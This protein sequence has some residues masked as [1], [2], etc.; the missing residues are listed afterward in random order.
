MCS[1]IVFA[2]KAQWYSTRDGRPGAG[3]EI[4]TNG[5]ASLSRIFEIASALTKS[6]FNF[7]M[8]PV[9]PTMSL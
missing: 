7:N 6:F 2:C 1:H 4:M 8:L 5:H 3:A 9:F